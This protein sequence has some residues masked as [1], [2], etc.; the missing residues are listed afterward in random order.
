MSEAQASV[1]QLPSLADLHRRTAAYVVRDADGISAIN[2]MEREREGKEGREQEGKKAGVEPRQTR[3]KQWV[4]DR[5]EEEEAD[6]G[7]HLETVSQSH[8]LFPDKSLMQMQGRMR[9]AV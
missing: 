4:E 7:S 8:I 3:A 6:P 9:F 5:R 1:N 2:V